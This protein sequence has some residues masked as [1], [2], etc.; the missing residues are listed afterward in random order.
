MTSTQIFWFL[1]VTVLYYYWCLY[2][3]CRRIISQQYLVVWLMLMDIYYYLPY[4]FHFMQV[5]LKMFYHNKFN[6]ML[7][8]R[9]YYS[10]LNLLF[11]FNPPFDSNDPIYINGG[12]IN[13]IITPILIFQLFLKIHFVVSIFH[14]LIIPIIC[15]LFS[16]HATK[17]SL[18][19]NWESHITTLL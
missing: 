4:D 13:S 16:L 18:F 10:F 8:W 12:C 6:L 11:D 3:T 2:L 17:K 1:P 15:N 9:S 19:A 5:F 7:T 14:F